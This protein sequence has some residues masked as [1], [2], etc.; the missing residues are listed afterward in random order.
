MSGLEFGLTVIRILLSLGQTVGVGI[1]GVGLQRRMMLATAVQEVCCRLLIDQ[2]LRF[3]GICG[4]E[5][6]LC[7]VAL[8]AGFVETGL[9]LAQLTGLTTRKRSRI[10]AVAHVK[11]TNRLR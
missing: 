4:C 9:R 8:L 11:A 1:R 10:H 6:S 5:S 7:F 2:Q 3:I